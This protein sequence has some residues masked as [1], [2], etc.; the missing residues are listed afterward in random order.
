[1]NFNR[2]LILFF[3]AIIIGDV[4]FAQQLN[5]PSNR[6]NTRGSTDYFNIPR[7]ALSIRGFD[8]TA[9]DQFN[10]THSTKTFGVKQVLERAYGVGRNIDPVVNEIFID[11]IDEAS[12]D[13]ESFSSNNGKSKNRSI[14]EARAFI[15]LMTFVI[16]TNPTIFT[17]TLRNTYPNM[18]SHSTA[19]SDLRSAL[20]AENDGY[21]RTGVSS[22]DAFKRGTGLMQV[23]RAWDLYLALE[24]GYEDLGAQFPWLIDDQKLLHPTAI[25]PAWNL[26]IRE[27]LEQ[28]RGTKA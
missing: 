12:F 25:K 24:N 23:S 4:T 8:N 14:L 1:M 28:R 10:H 26:A 20:L 7:P 16:E 21:F 18:P 6:K 2:R 11:L 15:A 5:M 22:N 9:S 3:I 17:N 13:L 27:E 19:I